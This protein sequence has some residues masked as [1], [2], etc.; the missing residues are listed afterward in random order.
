MAPRAD[1]ARTTPKRQS[2]EQHCASSHQPTPRLKRSV[3]RG[4]RIKIIPSI[5][6]KTVSPHVWIRKQFS[7]LLMML[8]VL[9]MHPI[10]HLLRAVW[11][12]PIDGKN[13]GATAAMNELQSGSTRGNINHSQLLV[14]S[15]D[16]MYTCV[17]IRKD[18]ALWT[19]KMTP[20]QYR[21]YF[22]SEHVIWL[23]LSDPE[24]D[25][26]LVFYWI[27]ESRLHWC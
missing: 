10:F 25:Q 26:H 2:A 8:L 22:W 20:S 19:K 3:T 13:K 1:D 24:Y 5:N 17:H 6:H 27:I 16:G 11:E 12:E 4:I 15:E 14:V 23:W 7:W 18:G 9:F 21:M